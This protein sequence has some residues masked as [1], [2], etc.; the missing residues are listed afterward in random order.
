M[1]A[2][3]EMKA[4]ENWLEKKE[5]CLYGLCDGSGIEVIGEFDDIR[6]RVCPCSQKVEDE[7]DNQLD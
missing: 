5:E 6:E 2:T 3:K 7:D 1:T 4:V